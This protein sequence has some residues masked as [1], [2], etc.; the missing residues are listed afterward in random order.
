MSN[1]KFG[2]GTVPTN[3]KF[4][5]TVPMKL[6]LGKRSRIK[7]ILTLALFYI[8]LEITFYIPSTNGDA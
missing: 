4:F 2:D 7:I 8:I 6:R 5:F 3:K 1:N